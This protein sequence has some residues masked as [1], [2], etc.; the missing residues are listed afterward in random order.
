MR[1]RIEA[2]A[3]SFAL[4][5]TGAGHAA[6]VETEH[7]SAELISEQTSLSP[8]SSAWLG[9]RLKHQ[10]H[11][12]TYWINPGDSGLATKLR[13]SLP[14]GFAAGPILWPAPRRLPAGA[15]TNFG[16]V[17]EMV[18]PVALTVPASAA[19]GHPVSL[20]VE[21]SWLVCE[22]VCIPG[23]ATLALELPVQA[24]PAT[25]DPRWRALFSQA[26]ALQPR[27]V[28]WRGE[29]RLRGDAVEITLRGTNLPDP[30]ALD[31]FPLQA[32]VLDSARPRFE[33]SAAGLVAHAP[34][35]EY[36][37]AVPIRLDLVL[38]AASARA[39]QAWAVTVPF[40]DMIA[41]PVP[42][43]KSKEVP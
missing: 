28:D 32:Q 43:E 39:A 14:E 35:S 31:L 9:V 29:A 8:G 36:F 10:P 40:E 12:H 15:L 11:W 24:A 16:Y 3:L 26:R 13:W 20:S 18:L 4:A 27:A 41:A 30:A 21:A 2:L 23:K 1:Y 42:Q 25:A 7:L 22:E 6:Q 5:A 17:D 19:A 38:T 33:R 37:D 34:K